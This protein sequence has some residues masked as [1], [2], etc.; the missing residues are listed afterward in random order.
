[1]S[2]NYRL[3]IVDIEIYNIYPKMLFLTIYYLIPIALNAASTGS[4]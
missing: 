2:A 1:M 3:Y 4:E